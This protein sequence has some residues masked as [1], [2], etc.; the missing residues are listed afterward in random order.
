MLEI[1]LFF[2]TF[3]FSF[4]FFIW[5]ADTTANVLAK[6]VMMVAM[7]VGIILCIASTG[8]KY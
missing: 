5:R 6:M 7:I 8:I 3:V 4:L 2:S 1:Y